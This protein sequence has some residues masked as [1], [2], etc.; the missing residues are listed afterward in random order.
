MNK[1]SPLLTAAFNTQRENFTLQAD[2]CI[3]TEGVC[4]IFGSSGAGKTTLLRCIAGLEPNTKGHLSIGSVIYQDETHF[5]PAHQRNFGYVFQEPSLFTH[6]SVAENLH[7]SLGLATKRMRG[8]A[9]T[10]ISLGTVIET[11]KLGDLLQQHP[12]QLSGGQQQRVAIARALLSQPSLLLLDEPL[13]SLDIKSRH[14]IL[15]FLASLHRDFSVPILY[16]SHSPEEVQRLAD[17]MVLMENGR[18]VAQGPI[19]DILT[20]ADLPLIHQ[21]EAGA[22]LHGTITQHDK[23][24]ALT[25]LSVPGGTLSVPMSVST[26]TSRSTVNSTPTLPPGSDVRVRILARDVSIALNNY[27]DSS[28]SNRL[29]AE[30]IALMEDA[31]PAQLIVQ[32]KLGSD[33]ILARITRRSAHRLKLT[34]GQSVVAQIKSVALS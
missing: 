2:L 11:L 28:I 16:I 25:E 7:F 14:E 23:D 10:S 26:S 6:L 3:P 18:V 32:L 13:A 5:I 17:F 33:V 19:N 9:A 24:Y 8:V 31:D 22:V 20:R 12:Q 30:I 34:V 21:D 4:A 27:S 29:A 15:P 1:P